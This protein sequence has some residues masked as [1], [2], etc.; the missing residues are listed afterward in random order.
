[1]SPSDILRLVQLPFTFDTLQRVR[2]GLSPSESAPCPA[3]LDDRE[4]ASVAL[5]GLLASHALDWAPV[6]QCT[7]SAA[8]S[9]SLLDDRSPASLVRGLLAS[10]A[11]STRLQSG[12]ARDLL[13][14]TPLTGARVSAGGWLP[15]VESRLPTWVLAGPSVHTRFWGRSDQG[16]W[17]WCTTPATP[18]PVSRWRSR[19]CG[20]PTPGCS[21]CCD[22]RWRRCRGS[23][24]RGS[25]ASATRASTRRWGCPGTRCG[26]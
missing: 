11:R 15:S 19:R 7:R 22:A 1:G 5:R 10:H 6:W 4:A 21:V 26:S 20:S 23:S 3:H 2:E 25:S 13:S 14:S 8:S 12:N 17:V 16:A 24:I 9:A 18:R